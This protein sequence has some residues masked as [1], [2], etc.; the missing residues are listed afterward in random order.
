MG[1]RLVMQLLVVQL[2]VLRML[3][4]QVQLLVLRMLQVQLLVLRMLQVQ[5]LMHSQ[6]FVKHSPISMKD[7][8]QVAKVL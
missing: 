3:Q 4:V 1:L 5:L 8:A 6:P 2:L 7:L